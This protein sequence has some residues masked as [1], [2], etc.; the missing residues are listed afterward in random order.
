MA[1]D[2]IPLLLNPAAG[3]GRAN[4]HAQPI[5]DILRSTGVPCELIRSTAVGDIE[6]RLFDLAKSGA[7]KALIA[8]GDGSVHEAI[9]GILRAE[10]HTAIGVIPIGT[11]NDFAKAAATPLDWK[12]AT[13][14]VAERLRSGT[15]ARIIDAGRMNDRFFANGVGIGFDA[16]I[17]R[18][19]RKYQWPI[20][21]LVYLIA[22]FEGLWDGVITPTVNMTYDEVQYV[23]PI[24]LANISNGPWVG[25][26]FHI[27]PMASIDDGRLDLIVVEPVSRRRILALLPKLI[28][29]KHIAASDISDH[30]IRNFKLIADAPVPSHLDGETQPMQTTFEIEVLP[31]AIS[32]L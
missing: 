2:P 16:K 1:L 20:G 10:G 28:K 29:G 32:L 5:V 30:K 17:N 12:L 6:R 24:T 21:D 9:N 31:Q 8:G 27:A 26:M 15:P 25:G 3:R 4:R 13:A 7:K 19:A 22:V 18:I 11:G 14:A 23:G